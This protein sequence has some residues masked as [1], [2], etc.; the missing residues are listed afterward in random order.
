MSRRAAI[1]ARVSTGDQT[2]DNQFLCLGEL[3]E[4]AGW[5]VVQ[6]YEE[7][8]SGASQARPDLARARKDATRTPL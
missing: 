4:R 1:Y 3:A 5:T 6:Q 8:A 2:C 7:T